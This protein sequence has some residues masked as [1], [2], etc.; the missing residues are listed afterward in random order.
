M[1]D[2]ASSVQG[3]FF[4]ILYQNPKTVKDFEAGGPKVIFQVQSNFWLQKCQIDSLLKKVQR[5][6]IRI[7]FKRYY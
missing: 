2:G 5:L 7:F 4:V 6:V 1:N 3:H